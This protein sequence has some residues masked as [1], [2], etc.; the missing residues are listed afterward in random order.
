M[1]YK[2]LTKKKHLT[3]GYKLTLK[4]FLVFEFESLISLYEILLKLD[5]RL[6]QGCIN[7]MLAVFS[8]TLMR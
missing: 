1:G 4:G 5:Q 2:P 6:F 3:G 8:S 7:V